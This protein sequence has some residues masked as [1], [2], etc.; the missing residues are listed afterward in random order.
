MVLNETNGKFK[1]KPR[2]RPFPKGNIRGKV[3]G[4][5]EGIGV[6]KND[7]KRGDLKE[8]KTQKA[9]DLVMDLFKDIET[10]GKKSEILPETIRIELP[11]EDSLRLVDAI[12]FK[13][14]NG[15]SLKIVLRE[16]ENRMYRLQIFLNDSQEIRP[17]TFNGNSA[18]TTFWNFL[19]TS[20]KKEISK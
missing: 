15:N 6:R 13:D 2:G 9:E 7:D 1:S 10:E 18:A 5:V 16:R 3:R 14:E 20:L 17:I 8:V 19:K 12:N 11:K 4:T